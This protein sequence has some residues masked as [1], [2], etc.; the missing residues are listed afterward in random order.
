MGTLRDGLAVTLLDGLGN[1]D[2]RG[3]L[4]RGV[5]S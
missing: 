2:P 5:G 1:A 3:I 4:D